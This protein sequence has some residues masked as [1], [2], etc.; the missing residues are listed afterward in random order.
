MAFGFL[1]FAAAGLLNPRRAALWWPFAALDLGMLLLST[2]K[3]SLVAHMVR[4]EIRMVSPSLYLGVVWLWRRRVAWFT[5]R[6]IPSRTSESRSG[7]N[8]CEPTMS[9]MRAIHSFTVTSSGTSSPR[10]E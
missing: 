4:D 7:L 2:S 3:T 10:L 8:M 6:G 5:L 1:I 9:P